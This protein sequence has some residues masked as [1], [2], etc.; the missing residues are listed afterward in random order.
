MRLSARTAHPVP[1]ECRPTAR[2]LR[3]RRRGT[4]ARAAFVV[5]VGGC[6]A[7]PIRCGSGAARRRAANA[8][9][10]AGGGRAGGAY[11][12]SPK[13]AARF[14][15]CCAAKFWHT[16][17]TAGCR[18]LLVQVAFA[19]QSR[20]PWHRAVRI[21]MPWPRPQCPRQSPTHAA[22]HLP[23]AAQVQPA[24]LSMPAVR[25]G[26]R[27]SPAI[28]S[29]RRNV[30]GIGRHKHAARTR[31]APCPTHTGSG[32]ARPCR[33]TPKQPA[34]PPSSRCRTV[35]QAGRC[36]AAAEH[37]RPD[38]TA[39]AAPAPPHAGG[40]PVRPGR[41]GVAKH[42]RGACGSPFQLGGGACQPSKTGAI[43]TV[44]TALRRRTHAGDS[45][46][47]KRCRTSEKAAC[48]LKTEV[49]AAFG[50]RRIRPCARQSR[51]KG[52][53]LCHGRLF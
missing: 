32:A 21:R 34:T 24:M 40:Q 16:A 39:S 13:A 6:A 38:R 30:L 10:R 18:W 22:F 45:A 4:N 20:S 12:R 41:A 48:T 33:Y 9:V 44:F 29:A 31:N 28:E 46:R 11:S 37:H 3:R 50:M 49:Q 5:P 36:G 1:R 15:A 23:A 8:P 27:V 7:V 14:A 43:L 53:S 26:T 35:R 42:K 47:G 51:Q 17:N 52:G 25:Q 19:V 2:L